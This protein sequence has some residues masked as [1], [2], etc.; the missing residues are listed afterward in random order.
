MSGVISKKGVKKIIKL[1]SKRVLQLTSD[2]RFK[3]RMA[4]INSV[5]NNKSYDIPYLA[6]YS[7]DAKTIY[8]DRHLNTE[9]QG[10]DI[11][12]ILRIHEVS[13]KALLDI[14]GLKYQEAHH[15]ATHL[16]RMAVEKAGLDWRKYSKYLDPYIKR[17]HH[18]DLKVVPKNLD[19]EPYADEKDRMVLSALMRKIGSKDAINKTIKE[20]VG[21]QEIK[22]SLEYH[23]EL[24]P[25]LWDG[26]KL[27]PMVRQKLLK[28]ADAWAQFAKIP[29][30]F[31]EDIIIIGGN[32]NYNYTPKSDID[33]HIIIDRDKLGADREMVDEYLQDKKILWTLTHKVSVLGY[34]IEPYA[35]DS[36]ASYPRGQGVYSIKRDT[37][38][39]Y[40]PRGKYDFANDPALKKKVM[41]YKKLIDTIIKDKMGV[42]AVK[43]LKAKLRDMRSASIAAGGEFGFEN[44]VFKELRNR[45]YLDKMNRYEL[46]MKDQELSL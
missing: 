37:W 4:K 11:S 30:D 35:Q 15:I 22:I 19:L 8:I 41:F 38:V 17:V 18:E 23:D 3:V 26:F 33:V 20:S 2:P 42:S 9:F 13:E 43:E 40:P 34:P 25:K 32:T 21:L 36:H 16:E 45:G 28:F 12:K 14:G 29:L 5:T 31:I 10:V 46:T 27:K 7:K 44:L 6:G 1:S 39:Q 24:N